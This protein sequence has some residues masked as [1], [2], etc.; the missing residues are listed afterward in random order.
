MTINE[1]KKNVF[2]Y[3]VLYIN[4]NTGPTEGVARLRAGI[5]DHEEIQKSGLGET[6]P[7]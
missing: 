2:I 3:I 4:N 6:L 7:C 1:I 5:L